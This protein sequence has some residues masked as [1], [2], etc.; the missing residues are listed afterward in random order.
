MRLLDASLRPFVVL[1]PPSAQTG[2]FKHVYPSR[3]EHSQ[4]LT[5]LQRLRREIYVSD[6]AIPPW[7]CT[8]DGRHV[9]PDDETSWHLLTLDTE[10]Q[11]T[12]CARYQQ[13]DN[14]VRFSDLNVASSP[15]ARDPNWG[16]S[17]RY[18]V[19]CEL[20]TA[21]QRGVSYV[22]IGGWAISPKLRCTTEAA[23]MVMSIYALGD[24]LGGALGISTVT[25][26][27]GSSSIL[28][29]LGGRSLVSC[30]VELPPYYDP[31][32]QCQ[33]ELLR[34]DSEQPAG[35]Y[36]TLVDRCKRHLLTVPVVRA[37][38]AHWSGVQPSLPART[39]VA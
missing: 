23:R 18:A 13:H 11:V 2:I 9:Q 34:F 5:Q 17:M 19:E 30:N 24:L 31:E 8:A 21:R 7:H 32:H 20:N 35:P 37:V 15:L 6:G 38:P 36:R 39:A 33:M 22:E 1:A 26:R 25:V 12:A 4:L 10:G 28:R 27:H 29:R 14:S 16:A 3:E